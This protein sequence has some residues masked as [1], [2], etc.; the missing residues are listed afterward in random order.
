MSC[1][2]FHET[3]ILLENG[4]VYTFGS[5]SY[6]Q[7]GLGDTGNRISPVNIPVA[8]KIKQVAAGSYHT[9]LLTE[10][11]NVLSFGRCQKGQLCRQV[12]EGTNNADAISHTTPAEVDNVG[13]EKGNKAVWISAAGIAPS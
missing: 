6:G 10:N 9:L 11:G 3:V 8:A 4:E 2:D 13:P 7:L 1:D 12:F 5:N